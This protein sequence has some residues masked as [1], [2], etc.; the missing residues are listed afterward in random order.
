M[1]E[2]TIE[3]AD[4][5]EPVMFNPFEPG[6]FDAPYEQY[7]RIRTHDPVHHSPID[8]WM[9]FAYEDCFKLLRD[10]GM[11]VDPMVAAALNPDMPNR[12]A[13]F[14][15]SHPEIP[16]PSPPRGILNI[17]PPDHTRIRRLMS[18]VFTPRRVEALRPEVQQLVDG[19]LDAVAPDGQMDVI[20]DL[21]FPLPFVVISEML[22][23]PAADRDLLR[24]WSHTV[25]KMLDPIITDDEMAEAIVADS[26]MVEHCR[27]AIAWKRANPADDLLTA[28]IQAEDEGHTLTADELLDQL[29]LLFIAGHETT[30]NLIGNATLAL[31]RNPDQLE[32]LRH[33][34]DLDANAVDELLRYDSP[35]QF[36][37]RI[38]LEPYEVGGVV[39]EA[40]TFLMTCLGSAN[41]DPAVFGD[42]ADSLDLRRSNP[43]RHLSFG[44]G[45][46]HCLGASLARLEAQV[47]LGTLVRRFDALELATDTPA[48]NNRIVLRGLDSLPVTF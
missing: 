34:P 35:V 36:S 31:L 21:A 38:V 11:S 41:H 44:S 5:T 45:V 9:L 24:D 16:E 28:L 30:V 1:S 40:G 46:H 3:A 14:R 25:V 22:G 26:H 42:D 10:P 23:M 33:D 27:E 17:D 7:R 29:V 20:A 15:Q 6:F 12:F 8:T 48:W 18:K 13:A 37:R 4:E 47:A 19:M 32:V 39:I 2:I 43:G